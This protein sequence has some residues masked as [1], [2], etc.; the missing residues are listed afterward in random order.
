MLLGLLNSSLSDWYFRLGSTN[1]HVNHYQLYNLPAPPFDNEKTDNKNLAAQFADALGQ[2]DF[3]ACF[4]VIE[5]LTVQ[6]PFPQAV[7]SCLK[8]LVERI[9]EIETN[10]GEIAR[11]DRS[12][13]A[14]EAQPIQTLIDRIL[15]RLAGL[16]D[17]EAE[18]LEQRLSK[19]L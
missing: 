4:S 15:F 1:A 14:V 11:T 8:M 12:E 19:M 17:A 16:T 13:L 5:P 2:K 18:G 3:D 9:I 6:S 7:S 10:R